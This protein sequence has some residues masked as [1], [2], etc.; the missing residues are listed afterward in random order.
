MPFVRA[1]A[2]VALLAGSRA[3]AQMHVVVS[4]GDAAIAFIVTELDGKPYGG[5]AFG[6][7]QEG[8]LVTNKHNV[9][10]PITGRA[11]TRLGVKYANTDV[12]LHAHVVKVAA[13]SAV[14]LALVQ[15]DEAGHYP[16]VAGVARTGPDRQRCG[17][18]AL[19]DIHGAGR[20]PGDPGH[21]PAAAHD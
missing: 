2:L 18:E 7:T 6:V 11:A 5:T 21:G 10:S 16:I 15:V 1:F 13:D 3:E 17:A 20:Q 12:L 19:K 9:L 8:L 14:D 4:Q